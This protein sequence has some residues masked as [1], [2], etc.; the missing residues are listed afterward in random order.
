MYNLLIE[1]KTRRSYK[2]GAVARTVPKIR[3]RRKSRRDPRRRVKKAG[4]G[5]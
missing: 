5:L 4:A 3:H 2:H 1:A